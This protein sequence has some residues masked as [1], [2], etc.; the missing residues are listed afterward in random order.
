MKAVRSFRNALPDNENYLQEMAQLGEEMLTALAQNPRLSMT[1]RIAAVRALGRTHSREAARSL[2]HIAAKGGELGIEAVNALRALEVPEAT[3]ALTDLLES[4]HVQIR[5]NAVCALAPLPSARG[6]IWGRLAKE[7]TPEVIA[8]FFASCVPL[9]EQE[10]KR[11]LPYLRHPDSDVRIAVAEWLLKGIALVK[12]PK[13]IC[14]A[15][16]DAW[17][18]ELVSAVRAKIK[19]LLDSLACEASHESRRGYRN[20]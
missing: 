16:Q 12:N 8:S 19:L 4:S 14:Q 6:N 13:P 15:L 2:K 3:E 7:S 5:K 11:A 9:Q 17:R 1:T 20:R 18:K 10:I